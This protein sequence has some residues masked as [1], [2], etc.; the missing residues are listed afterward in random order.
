MQ[1]SDRRQSSLNMQ[2]VYRGAVAT[3]L[4]ALVSVAAPASAQDVTTVFRSDMP[5]GR[6]VF[7]DAP[8]GGANKVHVLNYVKPTPEQMA[9]VEREKQR[10]RD[11]VS[12]M[13]KRIADRKA[14][15]ARQVDSAQRVVVIPAQT[16]QVVY[17][18]RYITPSPSGQHGGAHSTITG[19]GAASGAQAG[20]I[21]SGFATAR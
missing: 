4:G 19:P 1:K 18:T 15:E 14:E 21:G 10:L 7:G 9:A 6:V 2:S 13:D 20:F 11:R 8:V 17:G 16:P 5:D 3:I 12:A